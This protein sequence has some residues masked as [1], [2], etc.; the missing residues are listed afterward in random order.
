MSEENIKNISWDDKLNILSAE[1]SKDILIYIQNLKTLGEAWSQ[2]D[3]IR[4]SNIHCFIADIVK[5]YLEKIFIKRQQIIFEHYVKVRE[6]CK[7]MYEPKSK[8]VKDCVDCRI[9][10]C[11]W[12]FMPFALSE[13]NELKAFIEKVEGG[14]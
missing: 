9:S 6:K 11:I 7:K 4:K 1:I 13:D 5:G 14:E 8:T 12:D 10:K 3:D 2:C